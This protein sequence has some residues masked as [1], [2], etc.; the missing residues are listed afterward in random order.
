M[1][2]YWGNGEKVGGYTPYLSLRF[3]CRDKLGHITIE[4][5]MEIDDGGS[6]DKHNCCF[7]VDT[8]IGLLQKFGKDLERINT[9]VLEIK[10]SLFDDWE[11][12]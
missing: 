2:I 1:C 6:P 5:Y 9:P 8:E 12:T 3:S 10:V 11:A 4:V 7:Y